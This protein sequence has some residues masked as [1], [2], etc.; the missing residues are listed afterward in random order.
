MVRNNGIV[1]VLGVVLVMVCLLQGGA[2]ALNLPGFGKYQKVTPVNGMVS[3]PVAK[4]NDGKA[5]FYAINEGGK[6]VAF[7]LVKAAD[8]SLKTAF[9]ACDVCYKEKKGYEQNGDAMV[10]KNCKMKFATSKIGPHAVGGCNPSYLPSRPA[11]ANIVISVADL[12]AGA[13]YF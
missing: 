2:Y 3:I 5:H 1:R 8:G 13:R 9:D 4:V 11:G 10:C 12:R 6:E 7:F